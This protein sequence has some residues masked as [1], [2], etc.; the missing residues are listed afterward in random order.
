MYDKLGRE[1]GRV[2]PDGAGESKTY[3]AAGRLA[4]RTD[5]MG[6]TTSYDYDNA[7]RLTAR[8][9]PNAAENVAFTYTPSGRRLTATDARG[10]TTYGYDVRDRLTSLVQ[11]DVGGLSY[12]YDA[13]GN[14]LSL[15][16]TVG[17]QS[18]GLAYSYD[19]ASRLDVVHDPLNRA[20]DHGYDENGNRST[21][22][23][24]NGTLTSY[25][26][27]TLNRLTNLATTRPFGTV[28]SYAF[29]LGPAG[30]RTRIDEADGTFREYSYDSLYRLTQRQGHHDHG[31]LYQKDFGYDAVGNRLNQTTV[32]TGDPGTTTGPGTVN[33]G[34]DTRDRL[35]TENLRSLTYDA[36]GNL[37]AK[38]GDAT[39]TW[40]HENRLVSVTTGAAVVVHAYDADGN[41][42]RT[43]VTPSNGPPVVTNF[44]VDTSGGLSHVVAETDA[45]N[46]LGALY[47][48]GD[49]LLSVLRPTGPGTWSS[50]FYAADGIGSIRRLTDEAGNVTDGY[51]TTAFG[52]L[53][54]HTGS[55]PQPY[56]FAG[57]PYDPNS[58]FQYHRARWM[59]PQAGRFAGMDPF[60][61]IAASPASLHK[62]LYASANPANR[63]DPSGH[64]DFSLGSLS[65]SLSISSTIQSMAVGLT[66]G[67]VIGAADAYLGGEDADGIL[68]AAVKGGL[69][70]GVLGG[71]Y[72]V[73][74][75][76]PVLVV[77]GG[78]GS[79][80]GVA[81]SLEN[82]NYEQAGFRAALFLLGS[83]AHTKSQQPTAPPPG[84]R[85][86]N[87]AT[88]EHVAQVAAELESRGWR[89]TGGGGRLP[90]E[91]LPGPGPGTKGGNYIDI[92][93]AKNGRTLRVNTVDT[94]ANGVTPTLREAAAAA[95]IRNKQQ[96]D[97]LVLIPKPK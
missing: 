28:Q 17:G 10:T 89:I 44:L 16:A 29:T 57:E 51:A 11:P 58:G 69:L 65:V 78:I 56:L 97:H 35:L 63:V 21:L 85:L 61:G 77:A 2:L 79:V 1:V 93:A 37:T 82:E 53:I 68:E 23:Y 95:L 90:E 20:Y 92:T 86:G 81:D 25:T 19:D 87:A 30:N 80:V 48:R 6:R 60:A 84:G 83:I 70:G 74:F 12:A 62:Y 76:R 75:I 66:F 64:M 52:E 43:E 91:Y 72:V 36:N 26:Y 38:V 50:R 40:D 27:N 9:Y 24:P 22:Q 31:L 45:A 55:D 39:Y 4:N 96:S 15:T 13:N 32:G 33:Y 59:D 67:A 41:R 71:L 14:R 18:H 73:R 7:D 49:D 46:A 42:V 8:L 94:Y 88:R 3:D 34:Y 5:F 47:V 54:A